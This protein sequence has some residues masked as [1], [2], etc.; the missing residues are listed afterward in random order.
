LERRK[1]TWQKQAS[2]AQIE[3][4][5]AAKKTAEYAKRNARYMLLMLLSVIAIFLTAGLSA[6]FQFLTWAQIR[7]P[8][9]F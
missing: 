2:D 1:T 6:V 8:W 5:E 3:A 9:I 7:P 4:A